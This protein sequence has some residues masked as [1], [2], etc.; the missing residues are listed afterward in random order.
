[1][2]MT[3]V[4]TFCIDLV[5]GYDHGAFAIEVVVQKRIVE[6]LAIKDVETERWFVEHQ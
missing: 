3:S 2:N 6:L 4:R 5:R 1:M